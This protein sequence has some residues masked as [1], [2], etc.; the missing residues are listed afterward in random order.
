MLPC[1]V[2]GD[3]LK[4]KSVSAVVIAVDKECCHCHQSHSNVV[5]CLLCLFKVE[6]SSTGREPVMFGGHRGGGG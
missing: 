2:L 3:E 6:P 5:Q 4:I 1:S